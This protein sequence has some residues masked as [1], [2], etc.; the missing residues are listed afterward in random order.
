MQCWQMRQV[1]NQ[2]WH[3]PRP[4]L[5]LVQELGSFACGCPLVTMPLLQLH[6]KCV[7]LWPSVCDFGQMAN[8]ILPP[9]NIIPTFLDRSLDSSATNAQL[10][11]QHAQCSGA[12]SANGGLLQVCIQEN[13]MIIHLFMIL[14]EGNSIA[15]QQSV[16]SLAGADKPKKWRKARRAYF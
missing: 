7:Q 16:P 10:H 9:V 6:S 4:A 5:P 12:N 13:L 1:Q 3:F 8:N 15:H 14:V 11:Q 2:C